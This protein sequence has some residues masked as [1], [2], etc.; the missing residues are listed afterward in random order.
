MTDPWGTYMNRM[1]A[2][3]T[4]KR[5]SSLRREMSH[6][7]NKIRDSLAYHTC[8]IDDEKYEVAIINSDNLDEKY[9]YSMPGGELP[10]GGLVFW[11]DQYW[12]ITSKDFNTEVLTRA[13]MKQ[14]NYLLR[15]VDVKTK[16]VI[17]RQVIVEDSTKLKRILSK[18]RDSLAR[19]KRR[20][21]TIP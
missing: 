9:I 10:L 3:G 12:L 1:D 11:M 2:R 6:L 14:C 7:S 4:T 13:M 18:I 5:E 19:W 17:E 8:T 15:W 20:V 16:T 21:K